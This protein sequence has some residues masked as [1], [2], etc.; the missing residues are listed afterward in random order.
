MST[1]ASGGLNEF[2]SASYRVMSAVA[3]LPA[4]RSLKLGGLLGSWFIN[5]LAELQPLSSATQLTCLHLMDMDLYDDAFCRILCD[6]SALLEL[7][8]SDNAAV[9]DGTL[10][11]ISMA[12][13]KLRNLDISGCGSVTDEGIKRLKAAMPAL[14]VVCFQSSD[15]EEWL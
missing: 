1:R 3:G 12:T 5:P 13:P 9:G 6:F 4:L 10:G 8:V 14:E 7:D 11:C 15:E 2:V